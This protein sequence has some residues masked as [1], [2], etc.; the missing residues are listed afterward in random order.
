[1]NLFS[2]GEPCDPFLASHGMFPLLE[3]HVMEEIHALFS[4]NKV[5]M[6]LFDMDPFKSPGP[7]GLYAE[8]F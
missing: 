5:R 2:S 7:Y 3:N 1:M 4:T 6:V 8:F